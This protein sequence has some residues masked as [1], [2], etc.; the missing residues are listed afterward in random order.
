MIYQ[1][2]FGS[3]LHFDC[4]SW[5]RVEELPQ[6]PAISTL[7]VVHRRSENMSM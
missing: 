4:V 6:N 7:A 3:I 2:Q 5:T 1:V